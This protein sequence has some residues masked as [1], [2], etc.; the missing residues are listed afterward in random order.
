MP[1][2]PRWR[3][4]MRAAARLAALYIGAVFIL[5]LVA[6]AL[7]VGFLPTFSDL[8]ELWIPV[9]VAFLIAFLLLAVARRAGIVTLWVLLLVIWFL[10]LRELHPGTAKQFVAWT[11]LALPLYGLGTIGAPSTSPIAR[12]GSLLMT[13]IWLCLITAGFVVSRTSTDIDQPRQIVEALLR[14]GD[15]VWG[16]FPIVLGVFEIVRVWVATGRISTTAA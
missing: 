10:M 13:M 15:L 9:S 6:V 8:A 1:Q 14:N 16:P 11:V 4:V 3:R 12:R 5:L 7:M 2:I